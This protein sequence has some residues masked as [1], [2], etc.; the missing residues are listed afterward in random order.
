MTAFFDSTVAYQGFG[1]YHGKQAALAKIELLIE[2]FV[3]IYPDV[4]LWLDLDVV[5]GMQRAA[6]R[7]AADRLE[8]NDIAFFLSVCIKVWHISTA[9]TPIVFIALMPMALWQKWR[10]G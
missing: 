1:R 10:H 4:T 8:A 6:K 7:S 9:S 5:M 3:P 2:Q